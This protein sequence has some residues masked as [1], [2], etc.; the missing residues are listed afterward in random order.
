MA[1]QSP[2]HSRPQIKKDEREDRLLIPTVR[3]DSVWRIAFPL[4]AGV[5]YR[6]TYRSNS[7]SLFIV[8]EGSYAKR[9]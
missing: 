3:L 6:L 1:W 4:A 8:W 9:N 7:K 2:N 5:G